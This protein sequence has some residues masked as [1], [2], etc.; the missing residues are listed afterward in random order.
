MAVQ[1]GAVFGLLTVTSIDDVKHVTCLCKCGQTRSGILISH[2]ERGKL[3][4]CGHLGR[5]KGGKKSLNVADYVG[6]TYQQLT[7]V[8]VAPRNK[9]SQAR[10]LCR[11]VCGREKIISL[12]RLLAGKIMSCGCYRK[13]RTAPSKQLKKQNPALLIGTVQGNLTVTGVTSNREL[14]CS[15]ASC[16]RADRKVGFRRFVK[17]NAEDCGCLVLRQKKIG[18][19]S[20]SDDVM[21]AYKQVFKSFSKTAKK[22]K[23]DMALTFEQ[24]HSLV[25]Q[26]CFYTD[27]PPRKIVVTLSRGNTMARSVEIAA[28]SL[29]RIDSVLGYTLE[30]VVPCNLTLNVM[31]RD[32]PLELFVKICKMVAEKFETTASNADV[33]AQLQNRLPNDSVSKVVEKFPEDF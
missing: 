24:W 28:S 8:G 11:C 29:D 26:S 3:K 1:L 33:I 2:L 7:I 14:L 31:K 16:G 25:I 27:I 5:P 32:I 12:S 18:R 4:S 30:N 20:H 13:P 15:C 9:K 17:R 23:L 19:L 22:R 6:N 21:H 10:A